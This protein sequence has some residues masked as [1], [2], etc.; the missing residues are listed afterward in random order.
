MESQATVGLTGVLLVVLSAAAGLGIC[1]VIGVRFN[2]ATTQV[3]VR[4]LS[5]CN[6]IS[7]LRPRDRFLTRELNNYQDKI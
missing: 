7:P 3:G 2:A 5:H 1:S 6:N 4:Q